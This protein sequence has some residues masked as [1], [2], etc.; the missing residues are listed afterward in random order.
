MTTSQG[1]VLCDYLVNSAGLHAPFIASNMDCYPPRAVPQTYYAK[2]NYFK[3]QGVAARDAPFKRLVYPIP[4]AGGLGVHAT[5]DMEGNVKFGPNVEWMTYHKGVGARDAAGDKYLFPPGAPPPTD[6][7][8]SLST[9]TGQTGADGVPITEPTSEV[10]YREISK[11]WPGVRRDMLV[12]D[13][14]GI[15]PKLCGPAGTAAPHSTSPPDAAPLK[16]IPSPTSPFS[17]QEPSSS[18]GGNNGSA[19]YVMPASADFAILGRAAHGVPG[20]VCLFGIESPGLTSSLAIAD[21][22]RDL[23]IGDK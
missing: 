9:L 22:V 7:Q 18:V 19:S 21:H 13:Y 5:L 6:F 4:Q 20:L 3:M 11:Y 14:A 1:T 10:F 15:R 17:S 12:P 2:G 16:P 23:L 8:V